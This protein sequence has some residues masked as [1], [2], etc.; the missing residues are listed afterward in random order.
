MPKFTVSINLEFSCIPN[1]GLDQKWN[2]WTGTRIWLRTMWTLIL[3]HRLAS[4]RPSTCLS[5]SNTYSAARFVASTELYKKHT[6]IKQECPRI[7]QWNFLSVHSSS[8]RRRN[9]T[10]KN[11]LC[12]DTNPNVAWTFE[13][14]R[15]ENADE[16]NA[17]PLQFHP[18]ICFY[19]TSG[20]ILQNVRPTDIS[21][22]WP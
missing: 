10:D 22:L 15:T 1:H 13:Q 20:F 18:Q 16:R 12:Q 3:R 6:Q 5:S 14:W 21:I 8:H 19:H 7:T 11:T 9:F 4:D 17:T 2:M